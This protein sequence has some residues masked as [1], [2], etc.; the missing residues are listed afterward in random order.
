MTWNTYLYLI[1][2]I[3]R[4]MDPPEALGIVR[5]N[6]PLGI[7]VFVGIDVLLGIDILLGIDVL[8]G[9]DVLAQ[10]ISFRTLEWFEVGLSEL[11]DRNLNRFDIVIRNDSMHKN[12]ANIAK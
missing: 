3:H 2:I 4:D 10:S 11:V 12:F 1:E 6:V 9:I 8:V 7:N 5:I